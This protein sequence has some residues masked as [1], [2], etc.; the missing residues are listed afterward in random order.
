MSNILNSKI[1]GVCLVLLLQSI[2]FLDLV[3]GESGEA[4]PAWF[5]EKMSVETQGMGKWIADNSQHKSEKEPVDSYGMEYTWGAGK[6]SIRFRLFAIRNNQ[7]SGTLWEYRE[8]WHPG[9]K[10]VLVY[11]WGSDGTL[12]FGEVKPVDISKGK[13][14]V[15]QTFFD[16]DGSSYKSR[17]E[18]LETAKE[19]QT[20]SFVYADGA[21]KESRTYRWRLMN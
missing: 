17:H 12:G 9:E 21:W 15:E 4:I 6:K 14:E 19:R 20:K 7:E 18:T 1:I 2:L 8:F 5:E 11:Q 16:P 13:F 3:S 10:K